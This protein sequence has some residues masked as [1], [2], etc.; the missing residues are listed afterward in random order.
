MP[1]PSPIAFPELVQRVRA[2]FLE[3]PNARFSFTQLCRFAGVPAP[4]CAAAVAVLVN[5]GFIVWRDD[6]LCR[7]ALAAPVVKRRTA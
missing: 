2:L 3:N 1:F 6:A 7:P 4:A 5:E